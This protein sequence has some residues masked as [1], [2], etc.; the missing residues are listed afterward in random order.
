MIFLKNGTWIDWQT[1]EFRN[2]DILVE[3][4]PVGRLHFDPEPERTRNARRID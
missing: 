4:G 1:L 3:E 2:A